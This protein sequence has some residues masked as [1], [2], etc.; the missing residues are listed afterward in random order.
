MATVT[1]AEARAA[2]AAWKDARGCAPLGDADFP[3][4]EDR[5]GSLLANAA[6]ILSMLSAAA[7]DMDTLAGRGLN[8]EFGSRTGRM[9]SAALDGV[10]DLIGLASFLL[11]D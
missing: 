6:A 2:M 11:E 4:A 7:E 3:G 1:K 8:S 5:S 9:M 10:A